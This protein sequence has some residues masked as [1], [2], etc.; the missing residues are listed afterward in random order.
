M[1]SPV[2]PFGKVSNYNM[3][4]TIPVIYFLLSQLWSF[5]SFKDFVHFFHAIRFISIKLLI[6]FPYYPFSIYRSCSDNA[7]LILDTSNMSFFLPALCA[8]SE[9]MGGIRQDKKIPFQVNSCV[10]N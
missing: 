5:E 9:N 4:K 2:K 1:K 7:P 8:S 6:I 3:N 10:K